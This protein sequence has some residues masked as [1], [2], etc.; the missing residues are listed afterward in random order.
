MNSCLLTDGQNGKEQGI[1]AKKLQQEATCY[2]Q[3]NKPYTAQQAADFL[4]LKLNYLY[5]LV[6]NKKIP[7]YK[8]NG[9]ILYFRESDLVA[10]A[11]RGRQA[12]DFELKD[13]AIKL[14]KG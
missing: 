12:A 4:G 6:Y 7:V 9:K 11:F 14:L 3:M 13:Q 1:P 10:Y 8:P 2:C 5:N